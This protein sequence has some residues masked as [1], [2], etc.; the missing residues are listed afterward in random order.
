[1]YI[2]FSLILALAFMAVTFDWRTQD[3]L[4]GV[5]I[6]GF[7]VFLFWGIINY[8]ALPVMAIWNYGLWTEVILTLLL[9]AIV[10]ATEEDEYW[11]LLLPTGVLVLML[12]IAVGSS[13]AFHS[14]E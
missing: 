10:Y 14:E 12:C 5:L 4:I 3:N 6:G 11:R 7:L 9:G 8:F 1:M 13:A 2:I